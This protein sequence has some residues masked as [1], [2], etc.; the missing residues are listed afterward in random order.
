MKCMA[1]RACFLKRDR[2]IYAMTARAA[3]GIRMIFMRVVFAI[4]CKQAEQGEGSSSS[5]R[6]NGTFADCREAMR[7]SHCERCLILPELNITVGL[8]LKK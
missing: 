6:K 4:E 8:S 7:A 3:F 5:A 2:T 1:V